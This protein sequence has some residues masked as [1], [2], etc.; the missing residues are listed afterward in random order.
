LRKFAR[1]IEVRDCHSHYWARSAVGIGLISEDRESIVAPEGGITAA[2]II[3][4]EAGGVE[5]RHQA[6]GYQNRETRE[7]SGDGSKGKLSVLLQGSFKT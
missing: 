4:R 3:C 7:P 1:A 2:V 6:E 5:D